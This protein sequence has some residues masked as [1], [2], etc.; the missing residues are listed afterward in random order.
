MLNSVCD[1]LAFDDPLL[2][3]GSLTAT[4]DAGKYSKVKIAMVLKDR[5]FWASVCDSCIDLCAFIMSSDRPTCF[6]VSNVHSTTSRITYKFKG[7]VKSHLQTCN[8]LK[9]TLGACD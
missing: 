4:K 2:S 3:L 8:T 7:I 5:E 1:V 6:H 9:Q